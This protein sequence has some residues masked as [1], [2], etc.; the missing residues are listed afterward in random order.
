MSL[1]RKMKAQF[2]VTFATVPVFA[3]LAFLLFSL[4][5]QF[6][7]FTKNIGVF[8]AIAIPFMLAWTVLLLRLSNRLERRWAERERNSQSVRP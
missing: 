8:Y 7:D 5:Y 1:R 3:I 2:L 4:A 6:V